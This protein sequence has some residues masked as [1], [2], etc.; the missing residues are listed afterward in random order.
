MGGGASL[1]AVLDGHCVDTSMGFTPTGGLM[2][3]T[4]T[5]DLDPGLLSYLVRSGN[6]G[7]AQLQTLI[8]H[9]SGLLG[10]SETSGDVR[11]LLACE[12]SDVRAREALSLYCYQ[13]GKWFGSFA[14]VLGGLDTVVFAGGIG[15]NCPAVRA[16]ICARLKFLGIELDPARN[17]S[18]AAVISSD[19]SAVIVRMIHTDEDSVIA[20]A[21][22]RATRVAAA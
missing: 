17:E 5:G 21:A 12:A 8:N 1:A 22:W 16:R 9:E 11:D 19:D 13:A 20:D 3:A 18:N 15:E 2:M 7:V 10:V 4:R 14:A 6:L